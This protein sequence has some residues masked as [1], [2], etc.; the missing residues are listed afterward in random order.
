MRNFHQVEC[1]LMGLSGSAELLVPANGSAEYE[2]N[3]MMPRGGGCNPF[4][5]TIVCFID[6]S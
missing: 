1:D 4:L 5:R 2:L 3:V 6:T